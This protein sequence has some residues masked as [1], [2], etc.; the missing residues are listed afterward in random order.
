MLVA[1]AVVVV[2]V[3]LGTIRQ[4]RRGYRLGHGTV[5]RCQDGHLFT[6]VWTPGVSFKSVRDVDLTEDDR[7]AAAAHHDLR[8]P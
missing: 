2:V 4:R 3:A 8:L 1:V 7:R 6:T 5:V